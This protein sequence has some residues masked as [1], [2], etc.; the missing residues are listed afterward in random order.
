MDIFILA[1]YVSKFWFRI[2][3]LSIAVLCTTTSLQTPKA[4]PKTQNL[5][6]LIQPFQK[7]LRPNLKQLNPS[8]TW[9][10]N[11]FSVKRKPNPYVHKPQT[12][13]F[14]ITN[15]TKLSKSYFSTPNFS[16]ILFLTPIFSKITFLTLNFLK[17]HFYLN[18]LLKITFW[19]PKFPKIAQRPFRQQKYISQIKFFSL[20]LINLSNNIWWYQKKLTSDSSIMG[21]P[22]EW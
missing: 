8:P 3:V 18:I 6:T 1:L 17:F 4:S 16:K 13:L 9:N 10:L 20:K 5:A 14:K 22:D 21:R 19:H 15:Q 12:W 7:L 11:L 2:A